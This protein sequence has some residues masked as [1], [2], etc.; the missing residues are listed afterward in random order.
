MARITRKALKSDKFA[1]EVGLTVT[2]FEE[3]KKEIASYGMIA[4]VVGLLIAGYVYYQ[5]H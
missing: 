4:A 2:L 3:H 5:R 1:Q